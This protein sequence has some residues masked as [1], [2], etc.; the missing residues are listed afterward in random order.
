MIW[1]IEHILPQGP[2][3]L[4]EWKD[5]ISPDDREKA[6]EIQDEYVHLLGNLTLTPYNSELGNRTFKEKIDFKDK[7][8]EVGLKLELGLNNSID[9]EKDSWNIDDINKRNE[10]LI[11]DVLKIF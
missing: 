9:V 4:D 7:D 1:S 2:N 5:M 8:T 11:Q 10:V 6:N 3:L